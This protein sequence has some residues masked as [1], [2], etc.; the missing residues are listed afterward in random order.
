MTGSAVYVTP[1]GRLG[2]LASS[3]RYKTAIT[4]MGT[5]TK[6]LQQQKAQLRNMTQQLETLKL[7]NESTQAA[8]AKILAQEMS[9]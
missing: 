7:V 4:P 9:A 6:K 8:V 1:G 2:V 5:K 3:E